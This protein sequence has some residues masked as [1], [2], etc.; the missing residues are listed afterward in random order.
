[1]LKEKGATISGTMS[2]GDHHW[3]T[4]D[5]MQKIETAAANV[6]MVIITEKDMVKMKPSERLADKL[7]AL[8]IE[9]KWLGAAPHVVT[10]VQSKLADTIENGSI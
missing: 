5:D 10:E 2:W 6:S 9:T 4:D 1:M 8:R 7:Y 3:Y